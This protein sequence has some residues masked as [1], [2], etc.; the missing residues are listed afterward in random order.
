MA[1]DNLKTPEQY[2]LHFGKSKQRVYQIIKKDER[3]ATWIG[4]K[5]K[6][7]AVP[8]IDL[9]KYPTWEGFTN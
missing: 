1:H 6:K 9:D 7:N 8:F 3:K 5:D 2:A 4:A